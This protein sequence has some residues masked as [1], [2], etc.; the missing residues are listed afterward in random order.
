[1]Y[2]SK[3]MDHFQNPRNTGEMPDADGVG[4]VGNPNCGDVTI[5]YIKVDNNRVADIRFKTF[6]CAAAIATSSLA[7]EMVK[8]MTLEEA[9]KLTQEM[10]A[11]AIGGLPDAKLH[12]SNL[13][14]EALRAAIADYRSRTRS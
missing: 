8:G 6:G 12:C 9:E 14:P 13:A 3:V 1:M 4:K 7:T 11:A 5:V 2:N 10:V